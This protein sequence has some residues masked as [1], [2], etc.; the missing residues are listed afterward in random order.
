MCESTF[1]QSGVFCYYAR[2]MCMVVAEQQFWG[3]A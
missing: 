3:V 2:H 1:L